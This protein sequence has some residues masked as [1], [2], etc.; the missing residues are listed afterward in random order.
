MNRAQKIARFRLI[1]LAV[2]I[3]VI[4]I[5]TFVSLPLYG[6][7][8]SYQTQTP[9]RSWV[10]CEENTRDKVLWSLFAGLMFLGVPSSL[11]AGCVPTL[12]FRAKRGKVGF[13]ERDLLIEKK[14]V[15]VAA[16]VTWFSFIAVVCILLLF[17]AG[18]ANGL[19]PAIAMVSLVIGIG[20]IF[21]LAHSIVVLL[22]YGGLSKEGEK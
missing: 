22:Y 15:L 7:K 19:I 3:V 16:Q 4:G 17:T 20:M 1:V 2:A 21:L 12:L 6:G 18:G 10:F 13:D 14:A 8:F 9:E 5:W 11:V